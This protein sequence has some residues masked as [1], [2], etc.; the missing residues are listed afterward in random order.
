VC[1]SC[2]CTGTEL[3]VD[4][5]SPICEGGTD[6]LENLQVICKA[7]HAEK[8]QLETLSF[9]EE[10][11]SLLSRFSVETHRG[12]RRE[13]KASTVGCKLSPKERKS[14]FSGHS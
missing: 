13:P 12:V 2:G 5:I 11:N 10:S 4:L 8:T 6:S 7:C 3:E 9:V 14:D 1:K